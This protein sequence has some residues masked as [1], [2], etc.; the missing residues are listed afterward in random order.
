MTARR[1]DFAEEGPPS[2]RSISNTFFDRERPDAAFQRAEAA[3]V[4]EAAIEAVLH[5]GASRVADE[6]HAEALRLA[7]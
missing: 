3:R 5:M 6:T 1:S 4:H 7:A 2:C